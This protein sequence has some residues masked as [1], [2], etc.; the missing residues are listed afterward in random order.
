MTLR[1]LGCAYIDQTKCIKMLSHG[2]E[3]DKPSHPCGTEPLYIFF[4]LYIH[5]LILIVHV[6]CFLDFSEFNIVSPS[7]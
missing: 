3:R 4:T 2:F 5:P 1:T 6:S 7:P